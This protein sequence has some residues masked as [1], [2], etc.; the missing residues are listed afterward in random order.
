MLYGVKAKLKDRRSILAIMVLVAYVAV[1]LA[2]TI[3]R[4]QGTGGMSG[5]LR[6]RVFASEN[7]LVLMYPLYLIERWIRNGSFTYCAYRFNCDFEDGVYAHFWLYGDGKY[8]WVWYG[9]ARV[10]VLFLAVS[11]GLTLLGWKLCRFP[12]WAS[13]IIGLTCSTLVAFSFFSAEAVEMWKQESLSV[14]E[15]HGG[16]PVLDLRVADPDGGMSAGSR[17]AKHPSGGGGIVGRYGFSEQ[18]VDIRSN[19]FKLLFTLE[20]P[21]ERIQVYPVFFPYSVVTKTNWNG[22]QIEGRFLE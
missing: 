10:F 12:L 5:P 18:V 16:G 19:G 21:G 14:K 15:R 6:V 7:H 22:F 13:S 20:K 9:H 17:S 4:P 8:S 3:V 11:M 1:Y 2:T